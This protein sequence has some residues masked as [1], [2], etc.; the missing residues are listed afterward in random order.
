MSR[1]IPTPPKRTFP[2][3][4]GPDLTF[5]D[6]SDTFVLKLNPDGTQ[7]VYCGYIGGVYDDRGNGVAVDSSGCAYVVGR[8]ELPQTSFPVRVGPDL[9]I[10]PFGDGF[11]AKVNAAGTGLIYCGYI[12]GND[13]DGAYGVAVDSNGNAYVVGNTSSTPVTFPV[14]V[15]PISLITA[16]MTPSSPRSMR[17]GPVLSIA[18]IWAA[19]R[20][21]WHGPWPST[22]AGVPT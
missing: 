2:V 19:A 7:L 20:L 11:I 5:S 22:L 13:N 4:V 18:A 3:T 1:A 14:A 9:V 10:N 12:G 8:T 17:Q 21:I 6:Y 16:V 15:G